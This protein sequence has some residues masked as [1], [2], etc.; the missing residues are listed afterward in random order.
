MTS[1]DSSPRGELYLGLM[2]GTSLDGVDG[3]LCAFDDRRLQVLGHHWQRFDIDLATEL[4]ALNTPRRQRVAP[5]RPGRQ[6][7]GRDLCG[8]RAGRAGAGRCAAGAVRAIGAHGQ[9]VR[10]RPGEFDGTGYTLQLNAPALLAER[11]GIPVIADF[12]SRDVAAKG[13]GAPLVPAFHQEVFAAIQAPVA[14]LNVGGIANLT[15]V[16]P[17]GTGQPAWGFDCG[18]GN[19]LMDLWCAQHLGRPF[20]AG[21]AFASSG[22]VI[23]PLLAAC[24]AEPYFRLPAPK[25]TGR[26]LFH[27]EWLRTRLDRL[28]TAPAEDVQATLCELTAR[29]SAQAVQDH[30][31]EAQELLVCGGG[32]FNLSLLQRL[33][34]LLPEMQVLTSDRRGLPPMQ[35]EAAAFAWLARA[36]VLGRTGNLPGTTGAAGPRVLGA[37][38]PA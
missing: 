30:A 35:V 38:Y 5:R 31:G 23:E 25:S 1:P 4:L 32:A 15:V 20:D 27:G 19:I 13:Q 3:V 36:H 17:A 29:T 18:P 9:T 6:P 11:T 7:P 34:R 22:Q 12:R 24:L 26:D 33:Q 8:H 37:C 14:V 28:P 10:H 21:G 2:S 16:P